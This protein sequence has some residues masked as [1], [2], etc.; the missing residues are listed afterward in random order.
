[1][2]TAG[3][4]VVEDVVVE[5]IAT[6]GEEDLTLPARVVG[7][8]GSRTTDTRDRMFCSPAA[9]AWRAAMWS[10]SSPK[11]WGASR[12]GGGVYRCTFGP[13]LMGR[14]EAR[15]K[16]TRPRHGTTRN[17]LVPGRHGPL[18]RAGFGPRSWPMGGHEHGPF[19]AGTKRPI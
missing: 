5:G 6:Q 4:D 11:A 13:G 7:D 2:G 17:N 19:K 8:A 10:P 18:Y 3:G 12:V 9:W 15:K 1:L 16:K 14:P